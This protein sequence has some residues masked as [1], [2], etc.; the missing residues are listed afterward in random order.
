[1]E[2]LVKRLRFK[3]QAL[4]LDYQNVLMHL[5]E[6]SLY[7]LPRRYRA[8]FDGNKSSHDLEQAKDRNRYILDSRGVQAVNTLS[9]GMLSGA[10]NPTEAWAKIESESPSVPARQWSEVVSEKLN[11]IMLKSNLYNALHTFY[12]ELGVFGSACMLIYEHNEKVFHCH[13]VPAGGYKFGI[14][15]NGEI[16]TLGR[17][18]KATPKQCV[19]MF[20]IE[21]V[22]TSVRSMYESG[23]NSRTN[24]I[25][26][27]H[28]IERNQEDG[29]VPLHFAWREFYWEKGQEKTLINRTAGYYE[30]PF[31]AGRWDV[32]SFEDPYGISPGMEALPDVIQL[33]H[34]V[35]NRAEALDRMNRPPIIADAMLK[36]QGTT[37]A[38]G[39]I[40]YVNGAANFEAKPIAQ[41][42]PNFQAMLMAE[43]H[44]KQD[45]DKAFLVDL[46]KAILNLD[47]VRSAQEVVERKEEKLYLMSPVI[48]RLENE[49]LGDTI[50]RILGIAMRLGVLPPPDPN[51]GPLKIKYT[52]LL[53]S[54]Q[55]MVGINS[56]DRFVSVVGAIAG[57][58]PPSINVVNYDEFLRSYAEKM[59]VPYTTLR[60]REDVARML[61]E[62]Q[63]LQ[64]AREE[65][66]IGNELAQGARNLAEAEQRRL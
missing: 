32:V 49:C 37:M 2:E 40:T 54:A 31:I 24:A 53:K 35:K 45:I 55:K 7:Y 13:N 48:N 59:N 64:Q 8:L 30:K 22:S 14:D 11:E 57:L 28:L 20:G 9:S 3:M 19:E 27:N 66:V 38:P 23:N 1:M 12:K 65:A 62:Q 34:M 36:S 5:R 26:L 50:T 46:F 18:F 21:N 42:N 39:S 29:I 47:T 16:D 60:S 10:S 63:E 4:D 58:A 61:Q 43:E 52:S 25:T 41:I 51:V 17:E 33:Q 6:L 15:A 44:K 56:M